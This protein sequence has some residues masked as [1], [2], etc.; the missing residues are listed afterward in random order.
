MEEKMRIYLRSEGEIVRRFWRI[1]EYWGLKNDSEV[2]RFLI[3]WHWNQNEDKLQPPLEH[4]NLSE[5]GV[6]VLDRTINDKNSRGRIIN[7]YFK[8]D[9]VW[10][11]YCESA[12]CQHAKFALGLPEVQEIL[13]KKGWKITEE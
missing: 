3:N 2:L 8:Q 11:E 7:V 13:R 1:K 6:C 5:N 9:K 12:A 4:F 10:C